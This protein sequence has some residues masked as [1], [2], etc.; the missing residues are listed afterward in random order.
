MTG[1]MM[2]MMNALKIELN[3]HLCFANFLEEQTVMDVTKY[4]RQRMTENRKK[5][6]CKIHLYRGTDQ[7][8]HSTRKL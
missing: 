3:L 2:I 6:D 1:R 8:I 4:T 5:A 7:T